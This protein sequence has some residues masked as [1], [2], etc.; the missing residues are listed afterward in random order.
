MRGRIIAHKLYSQNNF[1]GGVAQVILTLANCLSHE[2]KC[3]NSKY[4]TQL[5]P[6]EIA[7]Y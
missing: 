4:S 1:V 5:F 6:Y 3:K 7:L 2:R